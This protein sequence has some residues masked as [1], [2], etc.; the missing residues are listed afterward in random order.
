M[1]IQCLNIYNELDTQSKRSLIIDIYSLLFIILPKRLFLSRIKGGIWGV[2][3]IYLL[4]SVKGKED[5]YISTDN[6]TYN[7]KKERYRFI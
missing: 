7:T 2:L 1:Y 3:L 5:V 4:Y 6:I